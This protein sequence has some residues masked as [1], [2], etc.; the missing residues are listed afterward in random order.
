MQIPTYARVICFCSVGS[1][2]HRLWEKR[3]SKDE[4]A[5]LANSRVDTL[6]AGV[7]VSNLL[8]DTVFLSS[9]ENQNFLRDLDQGVVRA[10]ACQAC[11]FALY[12]P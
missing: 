6:E 7:I 11:S 3:V 12:L 2:H 8:V 10:D 5:R 1:N 9:A 4:F